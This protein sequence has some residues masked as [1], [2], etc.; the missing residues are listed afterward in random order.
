MGQGLVAATFDFCA[1]RR[2]A[3]IRSIGFDSAG[4]KPELL[5]ADIQSAGKKRL[6]HDLAN[7]IRFRHFCFHCCCVSARI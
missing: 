2:R 7:D 4:D 5:L 3:D 6:G 1:L